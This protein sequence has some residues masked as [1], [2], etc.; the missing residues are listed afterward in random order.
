[1]AANDEH[2]TLLAF[3]LRGIGRPVSS[4]QSRPTLENTRISRL[5]PRSF[6]VYRRTTCIPYSY[7][8]VDTISSTFSTIERPWLAGWAANPAEFAQ[9]APGFL[10]VFPLDNGEPHALAPCLIPPETGAA[11]DAVI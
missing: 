4:G 5:F 3:S 8:A 1:M 2:R 11:M 10:R 9:P 6:G 7:L